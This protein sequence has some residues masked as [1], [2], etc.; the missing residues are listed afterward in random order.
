MHMDGIGC[1]WGAMDVHTW[2][3]Q[4][5]TQM[6]AILQSI[7]SREAS[8]AIEVSNSVTRLTRSI[9]DAQ[10]GAGG[11]SVDD[12][13]QCGSMCR[14]PWRDVPLTGAQERCVWTWLMVMGGV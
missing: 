6:G 11:K 7:T 4:Q 3:I 12:E 13:R 8:A 9:N 1:G 5:Y 14:I 10:T 2:F